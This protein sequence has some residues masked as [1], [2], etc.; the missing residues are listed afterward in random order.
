MIYY[1]PFTHISDKHAFELS[2]VV[3]RL[4]VIQPASELTSNDMHSWQQRG[5]LELR[6]PSGLDENRLTRVMADFK[7]WSEGYKSGL[8]DLS[9]Y[10]KTA[11]KKTAM[12]D[13]TAPS[14][15]RTQIQRY[16]RAEAEPEEEWF[17]RAAVF[18]AMA[19]EYDAN[20]DSITRELASIQKMEKEM[21]AKLAGRE[22]DEPEVL[23]TSRSLEYS[24]TITK[25]PGTYMTRERIRSW[26]VMALAD[27]G[28]IH[29]LVTT[30]PAAWEYMRDILPEP[31]VLFNCDFLSRSDPGETGTEVQSSQQI[32]RA[33]ENMAFNREPVSVS[34][35]AFKGIKLTGGLQR[36]NVYVLADYSLAKT[37][38]HLS[39]YEK[40]GTK[41][42][43]YKETAPNTVIGFFEY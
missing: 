17:M 2:Q 13:D 1:M 36:L 10:F 15:I 42:D 26:S 23:Q 30:S 38:T 18:L 16:Q 12:L 14:R 37:L 5:F 32:G 34:Q 27:E 39:Q 41:A 9:G 29:A 24:S 8:G 20:Q 25:D 21:V 7:V 4:A 31:T 11:Q 43:R 22:S 19:Q 35:D 3:D 40:T 6:K 33:F 28:P